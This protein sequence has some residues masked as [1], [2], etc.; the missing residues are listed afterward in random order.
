MPYK[1]RSFCVLKLF[2]N[3]S[4]EKEVNIAMAQ[5]KQLQR[6]ES[7]KGKVVNNALMEEEDVP[8]EESQREL[9]SLSFVL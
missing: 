5:E 4:N 3:N 7:G 6:E 1:L 9:V 2:P 8:R